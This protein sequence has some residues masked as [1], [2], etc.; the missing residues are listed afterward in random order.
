MLSDLFRRLVHGRRRQ[1]ISAE[2]PAQLMQRGVA[3]LEAGDAESAIELLD[4]ALRLGGESA[5]VMTAL[6]AAYRALDEPQ[7][8]IHYFLRA[9]D[10]P[11][12]APRVARLRNCGILFQELG[13]VENA[14]P[15]FEQAVAHKPD[16]PDLLID[17][18]L[19]S[20]DTADF[21][22][23][24]SHVRRALDI[25]P[26][27]A[28]AHVVRAVDRLA[29]GDYANGWPEYE[30][31]YA[32]G[33]FEGRLPDARRRWTRDVGSGSVCVTWEQGLGDQIMF[34]SC[35]PDLAACASRCV[36]ECDERL[37]RLFR[38]SFPALE[39][40]AA[41][42]SEKHG[43]DVELAACDW[44]IAM[45]SLPGIF[46]RTAGEFPQRR[47]RYLHA[48]P[49][50]VDY[51]RH[52]LQALGPGPAIGLSWRGGLPRSRRSMRS[53]EPEDFAGA[54]PATNAV[55]V[56]LQYGDVDADIARIAAASGRQIYHWPEVIRDYDET[57]ALVTALD[58][59][60]SVCTSI[61]HLAGALGSTA[62][63]LVPEIAEWRYG[64]SGQQMVWYE[65][66]RMFRQPAL[67]QWQPVIRQIRESLQAA[68][69]AQ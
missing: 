63:V 42:G 12:K 33:N 6:G 66:V 62:W 4:H 43:S 35:L 14:L 11:G 44:E 23:A 39:V 36:I 27:N 29:D 17:L 31:R 3:R 48:D 26:N 1:S 16:D 7:Q 22:S 10:A 60:L 68:G 9:L 59:V 34:A 40:R 2:H 50:R 19:L 24:R 32:T 15:M 49:A 13:Q 54:L 28:R 67:G 8:A 55:L 52:R 64:R 37:V 53:I 69:K 57:A 61:V 47:G 5:E 20:F 30:W 65:V 45:G 38:R 56:S 21:G 25:D 51:W 18:A 58:L 46:R 41:S